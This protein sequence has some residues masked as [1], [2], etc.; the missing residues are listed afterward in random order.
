MIT[1]L[2]AYSYA[3]VTGVVV[4]FQLC[5][6]LGA[7]WGAASMGGRFPGKYPPKMR[8]VAIVNMLILAFL[9]L[10]VLVRADMLLPRFRSM[11][12]IAIWFVVTFS[13]LSLVLNIITPSKTERI[14]APAAAISLVTSLVVA[15]H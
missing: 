13:A 11:S 5:L 1:G 15:F 2:A 7:P 10:V 3:V 9:I 6:A 8:S 12:N 4:L 14:W